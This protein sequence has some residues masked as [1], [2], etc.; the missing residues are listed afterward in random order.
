[1]SQSQVEKIAQRISDSEI[2]IG[3]RFNQELSLKRAGD[4]CWESHYKSL[5]NLVALFSFVIEVLENISC[6]TTDS[7]KKSSS[8]WPFEIFAHTRFCFLFVSDT[9]Y[10]GYYK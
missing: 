5:L 1:M 9:N 4:T 7:T 10:T 8:T 3:K 2:Q 6:D